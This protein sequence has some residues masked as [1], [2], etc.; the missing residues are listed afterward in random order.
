MCLPLKASPTSGRPYCK[1]TQT[2]AKRLRSCLPKQTRQVK[3]EARK[4][5]HRAVN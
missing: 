3:D 4:E 5:K 1:N 2:K